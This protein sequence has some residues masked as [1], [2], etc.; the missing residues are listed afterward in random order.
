MQKTR[1]FREVYLEW[2]PPNSLLVQDVDKPEDIYQYF[3]VKVDKHG[4]DKCP[5][6]KY[7][8]GHALKRGHFSGFTCRLRRVAFG[9]LPPLLKVTPYIMVIRA[10]PKA[11][12]IRHRSLHALAKN[13]QSI[14]ESLYSW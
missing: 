9:K 12:H 10:D 5:D 4:K 8:C 13:L 2:A 7:L 11:M 3:R 1:Q 14:V 6:C